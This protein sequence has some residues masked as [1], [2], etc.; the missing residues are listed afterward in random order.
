MTE[1]LQDIWDNITL[2][3]SFDKI[4]PFFNK[5][6]EVCDEIFLNDIL[7]EKLYLIKGQNKLPITFENSFV[8]YWKQLDYVTIYLDN[9]KKEEWNIHLAVGFGKMDRF[10]Q[11]L[12]KVEDIDLINQREETALHIASMLGKINF[13]SELIS[14]NADVNFEDNE[15]LTPFDYAWNDEIRNLLRNKGATTKEERDILYDDYC[16]AITELNEVRESNLSIM[17]ACESGDIEMLKRA[18]NSSPNKILTRFF[19]FPS[20]R[21]SPLHFAVASRNY[22]VIDFLIENKFKLDIKDISDKTPLDLAK[23][24]GY[25]EIVKK[26]NT[27]HNKT[28]T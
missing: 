6:P 23:D 5:H 24:L 22:I 4:I 8:N 11:L 10:K 28:F 25:N 12:T 14:N 9:S 21:K 16:N 1:E 7:W 3:K 27:A 2:T 20:N 17:N 19:A 13:V 26:I 18:Y 15:S